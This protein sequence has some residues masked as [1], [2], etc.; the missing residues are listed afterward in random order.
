MVATSSATS[1][2]VFPSAAF[3]SAPTFST[4]NTSRK[5]T[6]FERRSL[7]DAIASSSSGNR[8]TRR[9]AVRRR[10]VSPS[11]IPSLRVQKSNIDE[12]A[13]AR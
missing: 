6:T 4:V 7:P 12:Q 5:R 2:F 1:R 3:M 10:N 8:F 11:L 13:S 9:A